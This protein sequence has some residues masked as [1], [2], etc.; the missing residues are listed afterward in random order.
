[1]SK[2]D[3]IFKK[4]SEVSSSILMHK[5]VQKELIV[6][7]CTSLMNKAEIGEWATK[8][9][10]FQE[11]YA[12]ILYAEL[13]AYILDEKKNETI[14]TIKENLRK[15]SDFMDN[16]YLNRRFNIEQYRFWLKYK[17]HCEL[18]ILQ[19]RHYHISIEEIEEKS[20]ATAL[21]S[22]KEETDRVQRDLT[23]QLIG[24]ISIFTALSFVIFG[25][26]STLSSMMTYVKDAPL[27][28]IL[29]VGVIWMICMTNVFML[30]IKL[31]SKFSKHDVSL[32]GYFLYVNLCLMIMLCALLMRFFVFT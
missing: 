8:L 15:I 26:I 28:R 29:F 27:Q 6:L 23:G 24:L 3:D 4:Q 22:V 17:D 5:E 1:M 16:G 14:K 18:A 21:S 31:I 20:K 13:S 9:F 7:V 10:Q 19:R 32:K 25:G 12:K 11:A 30:F 2:N